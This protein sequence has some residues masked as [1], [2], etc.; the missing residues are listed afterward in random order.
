MKD[1]VQPLTTLKQVTTLSNF[2]HV[3]VVIKVLSI[4]IIVHMTNEENVEFKKQECIIADGTETLNTVLWTDIVDFFDIEYCY[5]LDGLL[6]HT[7]KGTKHL[8][9]TG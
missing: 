2:P 6:V 9:Y 4:S 8:C 1:S 5:Q 3:S 7:Y